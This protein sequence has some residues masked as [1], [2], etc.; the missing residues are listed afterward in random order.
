MFASLI[1]CLFLL[2]FNFFVNSELYKS[3]STDLSKC[4]ISY[5]RSGSVYKDFYPLSVHENAS[6]TVDFHFAVLAA[7]D[8]HIL[9]AETVNISKKDPA[10]EIVIGA[11]GNTFCDIRRMQKSDVRHS[12]RTKALLSALDPHYF[13][14][15]I[16]QE[17]LIQVGREGDNASFIEWLDPEPLGVKFISFSTWSGIEAKWYF[18]C[19]RSQSEEEVEKRLTALEK[20]R[21]NVLLAYD[22]LVRP[23]LDQS[24]VTTVYMSLN[25]E[26]LDLDE[27]KS[28]IEIR[29]TSVMKWHDE[30]LNWDA[31]NYEN[32]TEIHAL[33]TEIWNPELTSYRAVTNSVDILQDALL[34]ANNN[35]EVTWKPTIHVKTFCD[36]IQ[37]GDWPRDVHTC[38]MLFGFAWDYGRVV[39]NFSDS[40]SSLLQHETSPWL[41]LEASVFDI[42]Q[43]NNA[44][45]D[46]P[47]FGLKFELRRNSFIYSLIFLLPVLV[48]AVCLL[49]TFWLP[50]KGNT[51]ILLGS[52]QLII[53]IIILLALAH[54]VPHSSAGVP[55]II[56]LYIWCLAGSLLSL[57]IS[58]AVPNLIRRKQSKPLPHAVCNI[59]TKRAVKRMLWLPNIVMPEDYGELD[60]SLSISN[61]SRAED[62]S[63]HY[64]A[65]LEIAIQRLAFLIF[66]CFIVAIFVKYVATFF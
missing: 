51:K 13:W 41:I 49:V 44:S 1:F 8:A 2:D 39:L 25:L 5:S 6:L 57:L 36:G 37:L 21:R 32:L 19:D 43:T 35:G 46:S 47:L 55:L 22:P 16:T 40:E 17:G 3:N 66:V 59:L 38:E 29:G 14:L 42:Q 50:P 18:N 28:F 61:I 48:I 31:A 30:K 54:F 53:E 56:V 27:R 26:Y 34:I 20:L 11:G 9:L 62:K 23:V 7:S 52:S 65:L 63:Q 60:L 4:T 15:H 45:N 12:V 24:T 10:Y 64:W 33:R 58:I